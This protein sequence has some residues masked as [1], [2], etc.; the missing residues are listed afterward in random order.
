[1]R[2]ISKFFFFFN[3]HLW[4]MRCVCITACMWKS[5]DSLWE[6]AFSFY[7]VGP[8]T[9]LRSE[10]LTAKASPC[11]AMETAWRTV[12]VCQMYIL[13]RFTKQPSKVLLFSEFASKVFGTWRVAYVTELL[14][15]RAII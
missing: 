8:G 14:N 1:M 6:S 12:L 9:I 4:C 7:H 2:D 5:E 11:W 15:D 10:S 3:I 13:L